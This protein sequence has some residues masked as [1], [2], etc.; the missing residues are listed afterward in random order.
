MSPY[1]SSLTLSIANSGG[2]GNRGNARQRAPGADGRADAFVTRDTNVQDAVARLDALAKVMDSAIKIPGTNIVMGLDAALGLLPV[3]GDAVSGMISSYVIWEA[4]RLGVS[5]LI[6]AR[7][8]ANTAIDTVVGSVPFVG[9]LFD[10]AYRSNSKNVAL[11]KRHLE[12]HGSTGVAAHRGGASGETI[13]TT[14]RV[15]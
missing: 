14:Y 13:T 4:R 12:K 7:M 11:L 5:K 9:D 6:M 2:T 15:E 10:V 8:V 1:P 3:V